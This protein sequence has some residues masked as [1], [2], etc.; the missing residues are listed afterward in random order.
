[1]EHVHNALLAKV[2]AIF[3]RR[4]YISTYLQTSNV[5]KYNHYLWCGEYTTI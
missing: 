1:M 5:Q 3:W 4:A 2:I